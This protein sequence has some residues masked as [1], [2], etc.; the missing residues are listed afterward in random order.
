MFLWVPLPLFKI[1]DIYVKLGWKTSTSVPK[2]FKKIIFFPST[3]ENLLQ[4]TSTI[5]LGDLE[6]EKSI[7]GTEGSN[8]DTRNK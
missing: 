8:K 7:Y 5:G 1:D 3:A 2:F 4:K 6:T